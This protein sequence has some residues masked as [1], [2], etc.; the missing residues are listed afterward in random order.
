MS[1]FGPLAPVTPRSLVE[2]SAEPVGPRT[3]R[4]P[5][6]DEILAG[7]SAAGGT[8]KLSAEAREALRTN[9]VELTPVELDRIGRAMDRLADAGGS[10]GLLVSSKGAFTVSVPDRTVVSA[11]VGRDP[12]TDQVFTQIDSAVLI[13]DA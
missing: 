7:R 2:P 13:E 4:G 10:D 8:V 12:Q 6:F 3:T 9:G 5:S 1:R 11:T